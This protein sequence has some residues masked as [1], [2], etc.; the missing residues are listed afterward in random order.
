MFANGHLSRGNG[1]TRQNAANNTNT[2][3]AC[4]LLLLKKS[5]VVKDTTGTVYGISLILTRSQDTMSFIALC[6][7]ITCLSLRTLKRVRV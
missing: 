5:H 1:T 2:D 7:T 6:H 4:G 3:R